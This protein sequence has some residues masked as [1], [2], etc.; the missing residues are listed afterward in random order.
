MTACKRLRLIFRLGRI[1]L[2]ELGFFYRLS[3][4]TA[5]HGVYQLSRGLGSRNLVRGGARK[6][7]VRYQ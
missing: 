1:S 3:L 6:P 2:N 5:R 4:L 7:R